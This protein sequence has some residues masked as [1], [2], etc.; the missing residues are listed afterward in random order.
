MPQCVSPVC[1][2]S[3]AERHLRSV[4]P[5]TV[6]P[7][8]ALVSCVI[9]FCAHVAVEALQMNTG[10]GLLLSN[11]SPEGCSAHVFSSSSGTSKEKDSSFHV[12]VCQV[13]SH[14]KASP[15]WTAHERLRVTTWVSEQQNT[16]IVPH[17]LLY[18]EALLF[19][20]PPSKRIL[21]QKSDFLPFLSCLQSLLFCPTYLTVSLSWHAPRIFLRLSF[22]F[23]RM[24]DELWHARNLYQPACTLHN[25][26]CTVKKWKEWG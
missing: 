10:T 22:F 23:S 25:D 20:F 1:V 6:A 8:C 15:V 2:V 13:V 18:F 26:R 12:M 11:T 5:S 17:I 16:K 7:V 24:E 14:W 9:Q 21:N 3:H 4:S 19:F